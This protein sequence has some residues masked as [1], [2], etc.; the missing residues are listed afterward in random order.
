MPDGYAKYELLPEA[1][2]SALEFVRQL[3][4]GCYIPEASQ[5]KIILGLCD[6]IG[7]H[8]VLPG[9]DSDSS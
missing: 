1:L 7:D 5:G 4:A 6:E 9:A 2:Q 3:E 8:I